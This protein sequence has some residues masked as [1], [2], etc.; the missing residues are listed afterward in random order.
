LYD[1]LIVGQTSLY[2][3]EL[4]PLI[5]IDK[6][7]LTNN[8][9]F[10][11]LLFCAFIILAGRVEWVVGIY[12]GLISFARTVLFGPV[13]LFWVL[14]TIIVIGTSIE[15]LK[16]PKRFRLIGFRD[17]WVVIWMVLW[18]FWTLLLI[19]LFEPLHMRVFVRMLLLYII[20]P[21]PSILLFGKELGRVNAFAWCFIL[22]TIVNGVLIFVISGVAEE[23]RLF[24]SLMERGYGADIW[25]NN[26]HRVGVAFGV[27]VIFLYAIFLNSRLLITR[28]III[29]IGFFLLLTLY[30]INSRQMMVA[31]LISSTVFFLWSLFHLDKRK[32]FL[33]FLICIVMLAAVLVYDQE[34]G[35]VIRKDPVYSSEGLLNTWNIR[36]ELWGLGFQSFLESPVWGDGFQTNPHNLFISTLASEGIVG[37]IYLTGFLMFIGLQSYRLW[38]LRITL[39]RAVWWSMAFQ[40][41]VLFGL[42]HSQISGDL[43]RI[44][45]L[46]WM[47]A[48][49]W[50][51]VSSH[52]I[53]IKKKSVHSLC[54]PG[55]RLFRDVLAKST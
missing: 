38:K 46:Y 37:M 48:F 18:W 22:T 20:L 53:L 31:C 49:L 39:K 32:I 43:L 12:L 5:L 36:S 33:I 51:F 52:K 1:F 4:A 29:G 47:S 35:M 34:L 27:S 24:L 41:I 45:H 14:A 21:L 17:K 16:Q 6:I 19:C 40:C 15:Y 42:I 11:V 26:Y 55:R 7:V 50:S 2:T 8:Q 28:M 54:L 13:A 9:C 23:P 10:L 30:F 25:I 44:W 3:K